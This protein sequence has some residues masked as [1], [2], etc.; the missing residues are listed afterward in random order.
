MSA[1]TD[2]KT[3]QKIFGRY[4]AG[5]QNVGSY[6]VSGVPF[7]TG[8]DDL[9]TGTEHA[10]TF[11]TVTKSITVRNP[12]TVDIRVHFAAAI[13]ATPGDA[14]VY[15]QNHFLT[16]SGS[17]ANLATTNELKLDCKCTE[18]Y[19][20]NATSE[21]NAVYRVYAELTG[22]ARERMF[23]LTGSGITEGAI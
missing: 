3:G 8:S 11:P 15:T 17:A 20:S 12:G 1:G 4:Q 13:P 9:D 10:I 23:T 7:I 16:V 22:I 19:I 5:L 21:N 2:S 18:L 14:N 6:Q